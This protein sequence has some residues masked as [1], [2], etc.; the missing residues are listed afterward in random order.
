MG[1]SKV[2]PLTSSFLA[3]SMLGFLIS[4]YYVWKVNETWGFTFAILF[5]YMFIASMISMRRGMPDGQLK[6]RPKKE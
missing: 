2:A 3:A 6:G 5:A 4:V 1:L